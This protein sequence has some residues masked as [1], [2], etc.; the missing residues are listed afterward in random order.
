MY[1][2]SYVSFFFPERGSC[3]TIRIIS[4]HMPNFSVTLSLAYNMPLVVPRISYLRG[5]DR[6]RLWWCEM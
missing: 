2:L 6:I 5:W 1:F 3:S 4:L